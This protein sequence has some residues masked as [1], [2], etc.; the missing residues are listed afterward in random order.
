M[1]R[2]R[3]RSRNM[4]RAKRISKVREDKFMALQDRDDDGRWR[5]GKST[6]EKIRDGYRGGRD[7]GRVNYKGLC[8]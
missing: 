2:S 3:G 5:K 7:E 6:A 8:N 4:S 1:R